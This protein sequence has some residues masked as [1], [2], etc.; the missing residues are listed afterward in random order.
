MRFVA[1]LVI[2]FI[3]GLLLPS[4]CDSNSKENNQQTVWQAASFPSPTPLRT[5]NCPPLIVIG[6][7]R[8]R[9]PPTDRDYCTV[10]STNRNKS[11]RHSCISHPSLST[12]DSWLLY[13]SKHFTLSTPDRST[14]DRHATRHFGSVCFQRLWVAVLCWLCCTI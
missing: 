7:R 14:H 10:P 1:C 3:Y 12:N 5:G 2:D 4:S 6:G 8:H 11:A 9:P 13:N